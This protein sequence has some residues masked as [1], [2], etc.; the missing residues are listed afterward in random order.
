MANGRQAK[1]SF[2]NS[3]DIQK[4]FM[5][6]YAHHFTVH[7]DNEYEKISHF[8]LKK[9]R[10]SFST[11]PKRKGKQKTS[12]TVKDNFYVTLCALSGLNCD[13]K[14]NIEVTLLPIWQV[15]MVKYIWVVLDWRAGWIVS[16][17]QEHLPTAADVRK[18]SDGEVRK[19]D[20]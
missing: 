16:W 15:T 6:A 10:P 7:I 11:L 3:P 5:N 20:R 2:T 13:T 14:R 19:H 17:R 12:W 18:T 4:L 8:D 9:T 1:S